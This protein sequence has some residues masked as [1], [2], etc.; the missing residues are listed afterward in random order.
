MDGIVNI[1]AETLKE[2]LRDCGTF[3]VTYGDGP[4][5]LNGV[6]LAFEE[7]YDRAQFLYENFNLHTARSLIIKV[8]LSEGNTLSNAEQ[9]RLKQLISHLP[10]SMNIILGICTKS[11]LDADQIQ[12][13]MLGTGVDTVLD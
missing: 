13:V 8:L 4:A 10:K 9:D 2:A 7:A 11:N 3:M 12:I 6:G 5:G 1:D